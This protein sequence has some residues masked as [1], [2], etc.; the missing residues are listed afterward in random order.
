M[1][2]VVHLDGHVDDANWMEVRSGPGGNGWMF[3]D[4]SV[5]APYGWRYKTTTDI[6]PI[7]GFPRA[8]DRNR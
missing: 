2:N 8:F 3:K 7:P 4:G 5:Y 1:F 6:E